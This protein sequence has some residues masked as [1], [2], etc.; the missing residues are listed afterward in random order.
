M[1]HLRRFRD[2][3]GWSALPPI[4]AVKPDIVD[5]QLGAIFG[6]SITRILVSADSLDHIVGA[7]HQRGCDRDAERLGSFQ[8]D[9]Q[10]Q[11]RGQLHR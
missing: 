7:G 3:C 5:R 2:A 8:V 10:L 6:H 11:G 9:D 1:G 4:L